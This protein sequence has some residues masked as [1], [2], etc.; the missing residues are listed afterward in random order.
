MSEV[1]LCL[2]QRRLRIA[3][4]VHRFGARFGGAEAYV[5]HLV[6]ELSA[7]HDVTVVAFAADSAV[8]VP[9]LTVPVAQWLPGW[10]KACVF[11]RR[12]RQLTARRFD[13][14]H[15]HMNGSCGDVHT[16]HVTP[17]H[18]HLKFRGSWLKRLF[19]RL[20]VRK[21][22]YLHLER[23]RFG[24]GKVAVAVSRR[25]SD[26]MAA[27][28]PLAKHVPSL[29]ASDAPTPV[30]TPGVLPPLLLPGERERQRAALNCRADDMLCLLV[31]RNPARKGL[32]T[33]LQAAR[34]LRHCRFVVVG[35]D[36]QAHRMLADA[37]AVVQ[38]RVTLLPPTAH[39]APWYCA[40]DI[41]VHPTKEDT[42]GMAPLEAMAYGLPVIISDGAHC[43]LAWELQDGRDAVL[44]RDPSDG[45]VLAAKLKQLSNDPALR[46]RMAE[47]G[48][49]RARR[50]GWAE[51]A[52]RYEEIY[53]A[54][55]AARS[56]P[57]SAGRD[58]CAQRA[59]G[60]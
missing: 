18:Y 12:A 49:V 54:V 17:V 22:A 34:S 37:P 27:C 35:A 42:F 40:A 55:I 51:V 46:A 1:D 30:I 45:E 48:R 56:G 36:E 28:L 60:G 29:E 6:R 43:G 2:A 19:A 26:Q 59:D 20:S 33:V 9:V 21:Q 50:Q 38:D 32:P 4:L 23:A 53:A 58:G 31:A 52:R 14:I 13:V 24:P 10:V 57:S 3:M 8:D 7:R 16:V 5:E 41:Y 11:A 15:S 47:H 25:L 44:L 39:V